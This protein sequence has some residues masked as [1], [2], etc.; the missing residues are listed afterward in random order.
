MEKLGIKLPEALPLITTSSMQACLHR[1]R[2][3]TARN[4]I[5]IGIRGNA[6]NFAF[7]PRNLMAAPDG[8]TSPYLGL[9]TASTAIAAPSCDPSVRCVLHRWERWP[10]YA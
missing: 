8:G 7:S 10:L 2:I 5:V 1:T 4:G 6:Q 3:K 9:E